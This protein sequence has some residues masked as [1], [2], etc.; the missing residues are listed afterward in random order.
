MIKNT[1]INSIDD[2]KSEIFKECISV[3]DSISIVGDMKS[4]GIASTNL[5][6]KL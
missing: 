6:E 2:T 3:K 4:L 5:S 1:V